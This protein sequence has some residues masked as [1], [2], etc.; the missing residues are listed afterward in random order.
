MQAGAS[1]VKAKALSAIRDLMSAAGPAVSVTSLEGPEYERDILAL[2]PLSSQPFVVAVDAER[3]LDEVREALEDRPEAE[4]RRE[5]PSLTSAPC[6]CGK[7]LRL[8]L[9][10]AASPRTLSSSSTSPKASSIGICGAFHP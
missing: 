1:H 2:G 3:Q 4:D 9:L 10:G 8:L 6:S 7:R 5:P